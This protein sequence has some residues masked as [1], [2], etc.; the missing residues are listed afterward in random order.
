MFSI[1][2]HAKHVYFRLVELDDAEFIVLLR[3]Q[4]H[5]KSH[6]SAGSTTVDQQREWLKAYKEREL[7]GEE[8]YFMIVAYDGDKPLGVVRYHDI[9]DEGLTGGSWAMIPDAPRYAG[10]EACILV[11]ENGFFGLNKQFV[12]CT[13]LNT[14]QKLLD[15]HSS[16]DGWIKSEDEYEKLFEID[17]PHYEKTFKK[18]FARFYKD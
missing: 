11:F 10:I 17:L 12:R 2:N 3:N 4:D 14:N 15:F 18:K 8:F 13:V 7:A 9:D 5:V 1:K 16:Y 6:L